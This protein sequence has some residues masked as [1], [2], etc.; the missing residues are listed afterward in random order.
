MN[1]S[2]HLDII[3]N[4]VLKYYE[5]R[6]N[7]INLK[8]IKTKIANANK[9]V[10]ELADAFVKAKSA[11]LQQTIET[12]MQE[13]EI[14][15]DNLYV[16]QTKLELERGYKITKEDLLYFVE[17]LL[18]GDINDKEY[19][20]KLIDNLVY[21][22]YVSDNH[23]LV[24]FNIGDEKS[25]KNLTFEMIEKSKTDTL[26]VQTQSPLSRQVKPKSN[27]LI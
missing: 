25:P 9:E 26:S 27:V 17:E 6:T 20:Q 18:N 1:N 23:T 16:E 12:K 13:Y 10:Q 22:V 8:S 4:D 24:Y 2:K 3:I 15:L 14:L 11:L 5:N 19:Q 21:Q 7:E